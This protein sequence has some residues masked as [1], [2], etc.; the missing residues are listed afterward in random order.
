MEMHDEQQNVENK[1]PEE[2]HRAYL[3][4]SFEFEKRKDYQRGGETIMGC[5]LCYP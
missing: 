1:I 4:K 2:Q 5:I 3:N